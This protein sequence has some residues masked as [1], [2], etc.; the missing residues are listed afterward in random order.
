[1]TDRSKKIGEF[2]TLLHELNQNSV[3]ADNA[4]GDVFGEGKP[5]AIVCGK[6]GSMSIDVIGERGRDYGGI[7]GYCPGST[8]VKCTCCGNAI[9]ACE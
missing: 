4:F 7:T 3:Q 8:V 5:F 6:C 1:M 9:D 2:L